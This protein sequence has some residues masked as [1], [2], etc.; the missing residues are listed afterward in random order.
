MTVLTTTVPREYVHKIALSEVLL[1][2]WRSLGS[3]EHVITAQWPRAHSFYDV[4]G[5]RHDPLLLAESVRQ[6]IPFLSHAVYDVP[7]GHH[8]VWDFLDFELD[9]AALRADPAPADLELRIVCGDLQRRANRLGAV[10]LRIEAFRDGVRLGT[11]QTRFSNLAPAT[12]RRLRGVF[13][14]AAGDPAAR[15]TPPPPVPAGQVGRDR[16]SDVVLSA[17]DRPGRWRLRC[18]TAHPV[19][20]DHPVDHAPGMLLLEAARQ[21]AIA[22]RHPHPVTVLGMSSVFSR[23]AEFD[24]DCWIE[25]APSL[26]DPRSVRVSAHQNGREIFTS[27]VTVAAA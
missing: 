21:A 24:T 16:P 10:T 7:F 26:A 18:D 25:A 13:A 20:F 17:T 19:L 23:F 22:V 1:T 5:G 4:R 12:Y 27:S 2:S 15:P 3:D 6:A 11:A 8:Q 14:D 9:A